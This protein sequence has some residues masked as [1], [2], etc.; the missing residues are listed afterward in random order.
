MKTYS[1][2]KEFIKDVPA[3]V[4]IAI[5]NF[6][7]IHLGHKKLLENFKQNCAENNVQPVIITFKPHP[8][9]YF[10]KE[11][12]PFLINRYSEKNRQINS[13]GFDYIVEF[14]FNASLQRQSAD[15]F[16]RN[17]I[18]FTED[19]KMIHI[20][21]DFK[22]GAGKEDARELILEITAGRDFKIFKEK[23]YR[24]KDIICSS[25]EIRNS[26]LAGDINK[27][28]EFLG[29]EFSLKGEVIKGKGI[30]TK[31]FVPTINVSR[32][33]HLISPKNGVYITKTLIKDKVYQSITNVGTNPTIDN[34]NTIKI[35]THLLFES[36]DLYGEKTEIYFLKKIR[37]EKKFLQFSDLREQILVDVEKAKNY[38]RERS[39]INLALVGKDIAHSKSQIMYEKIFKQAVDYTLLDYKNEKSIPKAEVIL[40]RHDGF[41]ITS[42]YKRFFVDECEVNENLDVINCVGKFGRDIKATNTDY[43]ACIDILERFIDKNIS[44][45]FILGSGAM[46]KILIKACEKLEL[47]YFTFS[48]KEGNLE[49][50]HQEIENNNKD[51]IIVNACARE[52]LFTPKVDKTYT[53]WDLNYSHHEQESKFNQSKITYI[54]GLELLELQA[55][56]AVS[57]WNLDKL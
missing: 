19:V 23:P 33:D 28:N 3:P 39:S 48:R 41:S 29:R 17:E 42:P 25:T 53:F 35:E 56:Y 2:L 52:F 50:I 1:S 43:L 45:I 47:D 7:G 16:L 38:F 18:L 30:G 51:F 57:F 11:I 4:G 31:E 20:G 12:K 54:D 24:I 44:K 22:L 37:D 26:L 32:E 27:A 40:S 10:M 36:L 34:G 49:S 46:A 9:L 14:E 6:D 15:E 8:N 13:L 21:H 5:G 55:K